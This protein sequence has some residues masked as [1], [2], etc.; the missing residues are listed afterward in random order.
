MKNLKVIIIS[1]CI[2]LM[3]ACTPQYTKREVTSLTAAEE[4]SVK[5][6]VSYGLKDP[7]SA[8]FRNLRRLT[9]TLADGTTKTLI[10]GQV[11]GRNSFGGYA[12]FSTFRGTFSNGK[13]NLIG[14]ANSENEWIYGVYCPTTAP[15]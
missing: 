4:R 11:N 3:I 7:A 2:G 5:S 6:A 13:F 8:Q 1:T 9:D 12:G 14:I 15:T 10:C